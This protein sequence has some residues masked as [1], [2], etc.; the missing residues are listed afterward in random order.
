[1]VT[2]LE[3]WEQPKGLFE[4]RESKARRAQAKGPA[5]PAR[6]AKKTAKSAKKTT[7]KN[8]KRSAKRAGV[9]PCTDQSGQASNKLRALLVTAP[10]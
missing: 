10:D 1:M 3:K 4:S 5:R 7:L 9:A 2:I 8:A 6:S